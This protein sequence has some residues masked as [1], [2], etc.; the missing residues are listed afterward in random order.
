MVMESI[1][2]NYRSGLVQCT[3]FYN[4]SIFLQYLFTPFFIT[5]NYLKMECP[6]CYGECTPEEMMVCR[7]GHA[8][9][10]AFCYPRLM[11]CGVC[12]DSLQHFTDFN[13]NQPIEWVSTPCRNRMHGCDGW[14]VPAAPDAHI[15]DYELLE[16]LSMPAIELLTEIAEMASFL[17]RWGIED[18]PPFL[19]ETRA[20]EELQSACSLGTE[21][22]W[23]RF[24]P[25]Q[26]L[27]SMMLQIIDNF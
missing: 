27:Q 12:R 21:H 7:N 15:C 23:D 9:C 26:P 14:I 22:L 19:D 16:K 2:W 10:R 3:L 18:P 24:V 13:G 8:V 11:Y 6:I 4:L 17:V 20:L 1:I 25:D 5:R